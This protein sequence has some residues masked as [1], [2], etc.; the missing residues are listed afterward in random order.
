TRGRRI[1]ETI[2]VIQR[3]FTDDVI[4]HR[5]EFFHFEP[6][7]FL[8]KPVQQPWP[9][10]HIGGD[11]PAAMRRAAHLGDGWIPM[12]Q[13][14]QTL[15]DNLALI[16]KLRD[17]AGRTAPFQVTVGAHVTSVDDVHRYEDVGATRLL[18]SPYTNP[19]DAAEG[20]RRFAD[21]IIAKL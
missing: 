3:L 13:T 8:P 15:P 7:G 5:G 20:F 12:Q 17:D 14:L 19:W 9:P 1:D 11:S 2:G 10:M 21:E 16:R 4:E 18:V 6:V